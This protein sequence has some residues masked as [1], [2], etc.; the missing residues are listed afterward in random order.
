MR[1][2]DWSSDVCS[3]DLRIGLADALRAGLWAE[4]RL[5]PLPAPCQWSIIV[6]IA[7]QSRA[8]SQGF[9]AGAHRIFDR[10]EWRLTATGKC[11]GRRR[12]R[13]ARRQLARSL[14]AGAERALCCGLRCDATEARCQIC[15]ALRQGLDGARCGAIEPASNAL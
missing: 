14:S 10:A 9:G 6:I 3:S 5:D 11:D 12:E 4:R 7:R 13:F 2:S 15:A 1:I 8:I